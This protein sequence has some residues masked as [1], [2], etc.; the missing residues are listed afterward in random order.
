MAESAFAE[1]GRKLAG[2]FGIS[3]ARAADSDSDLPPSPPQFSP[4]AMRKAIE[5]AQKASGHQY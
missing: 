1:F 3:I 2:D 5:A 4:D